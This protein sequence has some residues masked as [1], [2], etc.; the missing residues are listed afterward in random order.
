M[1]DD[2]W[3]KRS[4]GLQLH[5][6]LN[7]RWIDMFLNETFSSP[8]HLIWGNVLLDLPISNNSLNLRNYYLSEDRIVNQRRACS[9]KQW[10]CLLI[11][12][13]EF[14]FRWVGRDVTRFIV[15]SLLPDGYWLQSFKCSV[16]LG[17]L[18][19]AR[20]AFRTRHWAWRMKLLAFG[21][22]RSWHDRSKNKIFREASN[23]SGFVSWWLQQFVMF[24]ERYEKLYLIT[25]AENQNI[26]LLTKSMPLQCRLVKQF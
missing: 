6:K 4:L 23:L 5:G 11:R 3:K 22:S 17:K 21:V 20:R 8:S 12:H 7:Y 15:S 16:R 24:R 18:M 13:F 10:N 9:V 2:W 25:F 26:C 19:D 14:V 1:R